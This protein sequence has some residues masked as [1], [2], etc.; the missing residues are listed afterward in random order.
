MSPRKKL[1][2]PDTAV[3]FDDYL[4]DL[5]NGRIQLDD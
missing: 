4:E 3:F 2:K 1:S 5:T